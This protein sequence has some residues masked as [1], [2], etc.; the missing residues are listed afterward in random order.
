MD[1]EKR[2]DWVSML[3]NSEKIFELTYDMRN[4]LHSLRGLIDKL[5]EKDTE[6]AEKKECIEAMRD[7]VK[8]LLTKTDGITQ[9]CSNERDT[10]DSYTRIRPQTNFKMI[11]TKALLVDDNEINDYVV[12][13]TLNKF[14]IKTDIALTGERAIELFEQ[15]DYDFILMDYLMP[16]GM[17]GVD[18][19]AKIRSM[20][21]RGEKQLIIGLTAHTVNEFKEG[22]NRYGVELIIFK[23]IELQ[24][25]K[26]ILQQE[27]PHKIRAEERQSNIM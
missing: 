14:N 21:E 24:Q 19:V 4:N 1:V 15:N 13:Q 27:L 12:A 20:G 11:N 9:Y 22:L 23:P 2:G 26:V 7:F 3:V 25:I 17:N 8:V 16:P 18:T 10:I 6:K 5:D